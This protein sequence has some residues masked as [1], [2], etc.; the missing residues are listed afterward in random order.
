[1]GHISHLKA[2]ALAA[3][4][5]AGGVVSAYAQITIETVTVGNI[6]NAANGSYGAVAYEF[7][8]GKYEVTNAQY[9]AFLNVVAATDTYSLYDTNMGS[10]AAGGITRSGSSGSYTYATKSGFETKPVNY[11]SF[12]DAARFANWL[13]NGQG[14]AGTETGSY[15]LGSVTNPVNGSVTRNEGAN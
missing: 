1:M 13:N 8:I 15:T 5:M 11:V 7:Q 12:W 14:S 3:F 2:A 6:G 4:T 10:N 9:A